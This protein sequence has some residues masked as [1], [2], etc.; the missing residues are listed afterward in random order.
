MGTTLRHRVPGGTR[1]RGGTRS[2]AATSVLRPHARPHALG[3]PGSGGGECG[4]GSG[5]GGHQRHRGPG[6]QP[7]ARSRAGSL[8]VVSA[9]VALPRGRLPLR[10]TRVPPHSVL[11]T[12]T[13]A[14][15]HG[16][17]VPTG[18]PPVAHGSVP[19]SSHPPARGSAAGSEQNK[20]ASSESR[21]RAPGLSQA[22]SALDRVEGVGLLSPMLCPPR[23]GV[24]ATERVPPGRRP[25]LSRT[26]GEP[27]R[28]SPGSGGA[29]GQTRPQ[30]LSW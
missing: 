29:A 16:S 21:R 27:R 10:G 26:R 3:S 2:R 17:Q 6:G 18:T 1:G 30:P 23:L 14:G 11:W 8:T 25:G 20:D 28:T 7:I 24:D 19:T 22:R 5:L 13:P 15:P 12:R 9:T 4:R